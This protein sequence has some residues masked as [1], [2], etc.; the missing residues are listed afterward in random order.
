[1]TLRAYRALTVRELKRWIRTPTAIAA[2]I[3]TPF[4][5]LLL[6]G[7][8]FNLG[9]LIP[10][11]PTPETLI[12][13]Q[14]APDYY[15]YFS[16]G[17]VIFVV[18][19][20]TLFIGA[21]VIFDKRLGYVKKL[22][23]APVSRVVILGASVSAGVLRCLLFGGLVIALA[24]GFAH[25]PGLAGLTVTAAIGPLGVAEI[26]VAMA[27]LATAFTSLFVALGYVLEQVEA[28]FALVNLVNLP[29][30][31]SS[32]AIAPSTLMPDWLK[33]IAS[34][35]PITLA[36]NVLR[37]NLFPWSGYYPYPP[38][39]YLGVLAAFAIAMVGLCTAGTV[40]AL[41]PR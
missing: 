18:V 31:F 5:Y 26:A 33:T 38:E 1:M 35:N 28:Y 39:L 36:V 20:S 11:G 24:L 4:F 13:F 32:T 6:F 40:R 2:S 16:A 14:G 3:M 9:K 10:S 37:E 25:L 30:L 34:G 19:F 21:N 27:L 41:N 17:M 7:Q 23:V 15:S 29:L 12:A 22:T 8:A